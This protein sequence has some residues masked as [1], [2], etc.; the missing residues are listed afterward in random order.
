MKASTHS[1]ED[2]GENVRD[3]GLIKL[4][5]YTFYVSKNLNLNAITITHDEDLRQFQEPD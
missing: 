5:H 3:S 2:Y 4:G 1:P